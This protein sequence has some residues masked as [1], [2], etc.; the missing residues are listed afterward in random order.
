MNGVK[1]LVGSDALNRTAVRAFSEET[2]AFLA[3]L[4]SSLLKNRKAASFPDIISFAYFCRKANISRIKARYGD[5]LRFGRGLALHIAPSNVPI[6]FAFSFLFGMLSGNANIV[7]VSSKPFPQTDIVCEEIA[8]VISKYP[9]L[10]GRNA[11]V[12]YPTGDE[13]SAELSS[14]ADLRIIWGGDSTVAAFK[15]YP[16]KPRCVDIAFSDRYSIGLIDGAA[17][18]SAHDSEI[19]A[20]SEA[21]YNDTYLMDQNACSSPRMIFWLNGSEDAKTRF[22]SAVAQTAE[23]KYLLQEES[24]V[25]KYMQLCRDIINSDSKPLVHRDG[26]ILYRVHP[27]SLPEDITELRGNCGYFY[28]H[29]IR[30]LS[31]ITPYITA[32]FQ[33]LCCFGADKEELTS[34]ASGGELQGIDRIVPFGK[35]LDI[36][37]I[38]DGYDI[39]RFGSRIVDIE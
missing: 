31:D 11:V 28:E 34:W 10:S 37:E 29:D 33:T 7:R 2:C 8:R 14:L 24:A 25:N 27:D 18:L 16:C 32:K 22:W 9:A 30:Q 15:K 39:I 19:K 35:S 13:I 20:L 21:F 23:K 4:S 36:M 6:N 17:V 1:Y 12:S 38:W 26:N 5:E 3:E